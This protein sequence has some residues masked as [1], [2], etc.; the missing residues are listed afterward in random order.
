MLHSV[1][2]KYQYFIWFNTNNIS[3]KAHNAFQL[4]FMFLSVM[5]NLKFGNFESLLPVYVLQ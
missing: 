5:F 4:N 3:S 1:L 2:E